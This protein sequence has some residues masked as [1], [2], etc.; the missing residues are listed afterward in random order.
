MAGYICRNLPKESLIVDFGCGWGQVGKILQECGYRNFFGFDTHKVKVAVCKEIG[1]DTKEASVDNIPL[2]EDCADCIVCMEV[3]E[4]LP[5][6]VFEEA[7]TEILR[8][9]KDNGTI[10]ITVPYGSTALNSY[11][12]LRVVDIGEILVALPGFVVVEEASVFGRFT[13]QHSRSMLYVL[14]KERTNGKVV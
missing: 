11:T 9:L 10:I 6:G 8:I 5:D 12:H 3:L 2:S 7:F 13:S 4:H 14:K 1:L